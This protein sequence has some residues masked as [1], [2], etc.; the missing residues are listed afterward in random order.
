M[1][2]DMAETRGRL[3]K[4]CLLLALLL[5][6]I[7]LACQVSPHHVLAPLVPLFVSELI[8]TYVRFRDPT[9]VAKPHDKDLIM[10]VLTIV[11]ACYFY[12]FHEVEHY[13]AQ[14]VE[15]T[16]AA[17]IALLIFRKLKLDRN[18]IGEKIHTYKHEV[19]H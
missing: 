1:K 11:V 10:A 19:K 6:L 2:L 18:P 7:L 17:S 16:V 5:S 8:Q 12:K 13:R 4:Y 9:K 3:R 15:E 14:L